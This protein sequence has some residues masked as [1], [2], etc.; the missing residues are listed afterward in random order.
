MSAE[1]ATAVLFSGNPE[2]GEVLMDVFREDDESTLTWEDGRKIDPYHRADAL[3]RSCE[4]DFPERV[5]TIH[6][7]GPAK[8]MMAD[9]RMRAM[10]LTEEV[11]QQ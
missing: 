7:N 11:P 9:E 1:V 8:K 3:R 4:G 5:W 10:G 2:T 6:V